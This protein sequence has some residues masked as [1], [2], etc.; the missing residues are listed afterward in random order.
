MINHLTD[1]RFSRAKGS[2]ANG[3]PSYD[4]T[5][6]HLCSRLLFGLSAKSLK[7]HDNYPGVRID[8]NKARAWFAEARKIG[9]EK[10]LVD[11]ATVL[12][13]SGESQDHLVHLIG[14]KYP[15]RLPAVY[16]AILQKPP[17]R[18]SDCVEAI[19]A[20]KLTRDQ[21]IALFEEGA[22]HTNIL[23]RTQAL[24]GLANLD[25]LAFRKHFLVLLKD[26]VVAQPPGRLQYAI[27][28]SYCP[29]LNVPMIARPGNNWR[30]RRLDRRSMGA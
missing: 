9:E 20:S 17:S 28:T 5:V 26:L 22:N 24:M 27:S 3:D 30:L 8:P 16:R 12:S 1:D 21:K 25:R 11:H 14:V 18:H 6:G 10:W 19:L 29:W 4:L 2:L 7:Q 15:A 23:H 13:D